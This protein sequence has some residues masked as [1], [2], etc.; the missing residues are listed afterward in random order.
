MGSMVEGIAVL[1]VV[2]RGEIEGVSIL[3]ERRRG[4]RKPWWVVEQAEQWWL[5]DVGEHGSERVHA[6][7]NGK[8]KQWKEQWTD[9]S[10]CEGDER[11]KP[12]PG[13]PA[14]RL[15]HYSTYRFLT[16]S[17]RPPGNFRPSRRSIRRKTD[18]STCNHSYIPQKWRIQRTRRTSHRRRTRSRRRIKNPK[19]HKKPLLLQ[20]LKNWTL[21]FPACSPTLYVSQT[22]RI[23]RVANH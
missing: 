6:A 3:H 8:I 4:Q 7:A 22:H 10:T 13:K 11:G 12:R 16:A 2:L 14:S 17:Q 19:R 9:S 1:E 23:V 20:L 18:N 15:P 21:P 5:E